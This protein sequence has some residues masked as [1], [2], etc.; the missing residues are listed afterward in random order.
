MSR[1][2]VFFFRYCTGSGVGTAIRRLAFRDLEAALATVPESLPE[3]DWARKLAADIDRRARVA[4]ASLEVTFARL[5]ADAID[6]AVIKQEFGKHLSLDAQQWATVA[7]FLDKQQD[8]MVLWRSFLR[9]AGIFGGGGS[10]VVLGQA[11]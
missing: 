4:G 9:W 7:S 8:G 6:T 11:R 1:S 5:N 10:Q 2:S 3:A